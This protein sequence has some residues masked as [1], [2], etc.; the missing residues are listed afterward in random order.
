MQDLEGYRSDCA[1][2]LDRFAQ[3]ED[4]GAAEWVAWTCALAPDAVADLPDAVALATKAL[5]TDP[6]SSRYLD[7]LGAIL[8]RAGRLEEAIQRLTEADR[9][10]QDPADPKLLDSPAYTWYFLA[11]AQQANGHDEEA[12]RW[13]AKAVKWTDEVL[14]EHERQGGKQ[15]YWNRRLTLKLLRQEAEALLKASGLSKQSD[16]LPQ[17]EEETTDRPAT[18]H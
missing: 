10:V 1:A 7:T 17:A 8:Y 6:K 5:E 3:T 11:M 12:K 14:A 13:L 4:A 16:P 18:A 9:L 2:M 15:L